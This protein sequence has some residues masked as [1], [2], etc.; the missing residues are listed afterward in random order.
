M[1]GIP[2]YRKDLTIA[3]LFEPMPDGVESART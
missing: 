1:Q 3:T 2:H